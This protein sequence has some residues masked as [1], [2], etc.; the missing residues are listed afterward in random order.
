V[1]F[2][3][4]DK[5]SDARWRSAWDVAL[6]LGGAMPA[7][8]LGVAF[9]NLFLGVPFHFDDL[10]RAVVTGSFF[11]LLHPFALLGGIVSLSMLILHGNAYAALKLASR[12]RRARVWSAALPR[13]C[14]C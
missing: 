6:T 3:F 1:G 5:L 4:L 14:F 8:L 12:W 9:T 2:T 13:R 7:L 10:R 11:S